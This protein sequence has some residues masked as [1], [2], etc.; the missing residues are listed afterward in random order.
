VTVNEVHLLHCAI[1][2]YRRARRAVM[3][4]IDN[5]NNNDSIS[6]NTGCQSTVVTKA[7]S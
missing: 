6:K 7:L 4:M 3:I 1:L 2:H 5:N